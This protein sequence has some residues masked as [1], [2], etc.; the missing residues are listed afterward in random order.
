VYWSVRLLLQFTFL[1]RS[2]APQG[3]RFRG[4]EIALVSLFVALSAT[5]ASAFVT[6]L[7]R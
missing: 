5:Y 4:A 7:S 2:D 6:N 3:R 1:D